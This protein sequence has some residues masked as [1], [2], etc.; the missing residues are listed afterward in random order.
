[1]T[2]E[3]QTKNGTDLEVEYYA[4]WKWADITG[5]HHLLIIYSDFKLKVYFDF[6]MLDDQIPD[7]LFIYEPIKFVGNN[8]AG[9]SPFGVISDFR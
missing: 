1:M 9:S 2:D 7:S 4:N 6:K 5:W 3:T 8:W